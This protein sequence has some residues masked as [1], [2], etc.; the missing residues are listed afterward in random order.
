MICTKCQSMLPAGAQVCPHCGEPANPSSQ[1]ALSNQ[2]YMN[3]QPGMPANGYPQGAPI[4]GN[5]PQNQMPTVGYPQGA[6]MGMPMN[7]YP[8]PGPIMPQY[9]LPQPPKPQLPPMPPSFSV[10]LILGILGIVGGTVGA[11]CW[12]L[13]AAGVGA[14][15]STASV[16]IGIN[17]SKSVGRNPTNAAVICGIVGIA[18]SIFFSAGCFVYGVSCAHETSCSG[19]SSCKNYGYYG[20]IGGACVEDCNHKSTTYDYD[21]Y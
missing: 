11:L 4:M 21:K 13:I 14:I 17:A 10:A 7:G 19:A 2:Q 15:I 6:P 20:V 16:V 9:A 3:V 12:G 8:Q 5:Y 18:M 1:S